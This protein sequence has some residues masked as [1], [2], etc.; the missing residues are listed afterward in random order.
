MMIIAPMPAASCYCRSLV[1]KRLS[2]VCMNG[3]ASDGDG[4]E[5]NQEDSGA[6]FNLDKL[7]AETKTPFR[8]VCP[9]RASMPDF[10]LANRRELII[11]DC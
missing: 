8:T 11:P 5:G 4:T 7:K 3:S 2:R 6:T 10:W 1:L 9:A